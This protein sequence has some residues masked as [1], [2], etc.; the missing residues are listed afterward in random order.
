MELT[1]SLRVQPQD[2][3]TFVGA[4]GKTTAM[5]RLGCELAAA[6]LG[7]IATTTTRLGLDQLDLFPTYL[8]NPTTSEISRSLENTPFLLVV[9]ELDETKGKALGLAPDQIDVLQDLADVVLVEGDGSRGL[10]IKAP[11]PGEPVIPASTTHLVSV[12][13]IAALGK[14]LGPDTAHQPELVAGLAD[15]KSGDLIT[16]ALVSRLLLHPQGPMRGAPVGAEQHVLLNGCDLLE[17]ERR[18]ETEDPLSESEGQGVRPDSLLI[19]TLATRLAADPAIASVLLGQVAYEPPVLASYGKLAAIVLAAGGSSRFGS[20]KQ[21][22]DWRGQPLLRHVVEQVLATPVQ[23]VFVVLG[24]HFE[25]VS[26]TLQGLPITLVYNPDWAQGQS[27]SMQ[28]GLR[29]C[30]PNT[31]AVLFVL[32]DQPYLSAD[33]TRR[34]VREH[35]RTLATI[36]IPRLKDRRGNP[37]LFDRHSFPEL[38]AVS[39]DTGGR[40]LF[41]RYRDQT[42]WVDAGPEILHDI[43]VAEDVQPQ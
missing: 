41:D 2:V 6:G 32:G 4:G 28:A 8:A 1:I 38:L 43:D 24:A 13:N 26:P 40:V 37:V 21:L 9:R 19:R 36:V 20:P 3:I 12:L 17:R 33:L 42:I 27:T 39:G 23:Q 25:E 34:L 15:A 18:L 11:G 16:P 7:V 30:A 22:L 29:A 35:Q 5:H 31:Q 10:P 14:P